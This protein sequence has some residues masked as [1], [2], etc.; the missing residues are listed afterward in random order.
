VDP[1]APDTHQIVDNNPGFTSNGLLWTVRA[2]A[3]A[4]QVNFDQG[5]ATYHMANLAMNDYGTLANALFGGGAPGVPGPGVGS[6]VTW[7][8]QWRDVLETQDV[9]DASVGFAGTFKRTSAHIDW[10]MDNAEGLHFQSTGQDQK[11]I[12]A[13]LGRERNGVYF[14]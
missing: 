11:V 8:M 10:S 1:L 3:S 5:I 14:S 4:V 6:T 7:S 9:R 2:P 12:T 13:L